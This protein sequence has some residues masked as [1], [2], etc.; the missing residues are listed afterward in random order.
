MNDNGIVGITP[1][2]VLENDEDD[3]RSIAA[4]ILY[5]GT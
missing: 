1:G 3:V 4:G 5:R 2:T